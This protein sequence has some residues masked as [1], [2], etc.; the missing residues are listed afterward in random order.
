VA[1]PA[2]EVATEEVVEVG[3]EV[4]GATEEVTHWSC[5]RWS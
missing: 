1:G 2:D 5:S 3:E 4:A